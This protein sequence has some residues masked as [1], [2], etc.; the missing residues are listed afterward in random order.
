MVLAT[1]LQLWA[2]DGLEETR[3]TFISQEFSAVRALRA[4]QLLGGATI[5]EELSLLR[6]GYMAAEE[7]AEAKEATLFSKQWCV[8]RGERPRGGRRPCPASSQ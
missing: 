7:R 8:G 5:G 4:L 6:A 2:A 3:D 1:G